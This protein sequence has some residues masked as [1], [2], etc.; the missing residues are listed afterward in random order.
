MPAT[1]LHFLLLT[2]SGW[3][4]RRQLAAIDYLRE[5][6]RVRR[7]QLGPARLPL[8]DG[9]RRGLAEKGKA[10][11]R[12]A[13]EELASIATPDTR[14]EAGRRR[15]AASGSARRRGVAECLPP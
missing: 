7:A 10:L 12:K 2:V 11:G 5:E 13:L 4:T 14:P 6:N 3:V 8:N 1:A 9:K 15:E